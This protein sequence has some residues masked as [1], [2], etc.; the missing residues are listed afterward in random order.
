MWAIDYL[1]SALSGFTQSTYL[2]QV[3]NR[4]FPRRLEIRLQTNP[5]L[6]IF[7]PKPFSRKVAVQVGNCRLVNQILSAMNI[8]PIQ[9]DQYNMR[10]LLMNN[11]EWV[12]GSKEDFKSKTPGLRPFI[13]QN[14]FLRSMRTISFLTNPVIQQQQS[15]ETDNNEHV[16]NSSTL[17]WIDRKHSFFIPCHDNQK[18][19]HIAGSC[20]ATGFLRY[21]SRLL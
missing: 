12:T 2:P 7:T 10:E 4:T 6:N 1:L 14:N 20:Y 21:R 17:I 9:K 18:V 13:K 11:S 16:F 5:E 8:H 3:Q 19:L 15:Y